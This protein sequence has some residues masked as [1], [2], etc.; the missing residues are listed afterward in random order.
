MDS[1]FEKPR[2]AAGG[3]GE[4]AADDE[5]VTRLSQVDWTDRRPDV[6]DRLWERIAERLNELDPVS[7]PE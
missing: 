7:A 3:W 5:L 4:Q 6:R 1:I 2:T